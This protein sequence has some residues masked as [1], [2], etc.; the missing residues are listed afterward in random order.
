MMNRSATAASNATLFGR[1]LGAI[2]WLIE[3][4]NLKA[5][6][7]HLHSLDDYL[8]KDIGISRCEIPAIVRLPS[9]SRLR[10]A[11]EASDVPR[12]TNTHL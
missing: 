5:T 7:R 3:Q 1:L 10:F 12:I 2:R 8:L 11:P 6:E 9:T 4:R